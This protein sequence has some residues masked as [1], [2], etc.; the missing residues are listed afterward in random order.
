MQYLDL[1]TVP[2]SFVYEPI[3][4]NGEFILC[5]FVCRTASDSFLTLLSSNLHHKV[6]KPIIKAV[7]GAATT[8]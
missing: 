1:I 6:P 7:R 2:L 3:F 4:S 5:K 8:Q